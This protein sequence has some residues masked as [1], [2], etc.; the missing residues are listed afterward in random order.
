MAEQK[1]EQKGVNQVME[2]LNQGEQPHLTLNHIQSNRFQ[3]PKSQKDPY[4]YPFQWAKM[5][6]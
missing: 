4:K 2:G 1:I 6:G 3:C 5:W